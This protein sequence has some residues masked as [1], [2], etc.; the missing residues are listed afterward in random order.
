MNLR[1][2]RKKE[3]RIEDRRRHRHRHTITS[4]SSE[5]RVGAMMVQLVSGWVNRRTWP[6]AGKFNKSTMAGMLKYRLMISWACTPW[7]STFS[8]AGT[9]LY[10][11][12]YT[13]VEVISLALM[14]HLKLRCTYI[15]MCADTYIHYNNVYSS[16]GTNCSPVAG[17]ECLCSMSRT[18]MSSRTARRWQCG[19]S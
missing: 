9:L 8:W 7:G 11:H 10:T 1:L 4:W 15:C 3:E 2:H 6:R 17:D 19:V 16:F 18:R 5:R 12:T 14:R 13:L